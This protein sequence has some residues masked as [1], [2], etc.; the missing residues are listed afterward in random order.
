MSLLL[1]DL[2]WK[3]NLYFWC[4]HYAFFIG[5]QVCMA[6]TTFSLWAFLKYY[7][8][9]ISKCDATTMVPVISKQSS[10][11]GVRKSLW[12]KNDE[13]P[14]VAEEHLHSGINSISRQEYYSVFRS[15]HILVTKIHECLSNLAYIAVKNKWLGRYTRGL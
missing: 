9:I 15:L 3:S 5:R 1:S 13:L 2:C 12:V 7:Q 6:Q 10:K 14:H 11:V 4:S 8:R